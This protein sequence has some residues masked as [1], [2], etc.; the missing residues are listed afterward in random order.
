MNHSTLLPS[1][2]CLLASGGIA[3]AEPTAAETAKTDEKTGELSQALQ[4]FELASFQNVKS[5]RCIGVDGAS[6]ANGAL[7]KQFSCDS[8]SNQNWHIQRSG[9]EHTM[10]NQKSNRC[11]GVSG[12]SKTAGAN[13][14]QFG[15][16]G[17]ANQAWVLEALGG[18]TA[19]PIARF[20]NVNSNMCLGVDGAS[21]A[22]GAQLKQFPCDGSVNQQWRLIER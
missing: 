1:V 19:N 12:A 9:I 3:S 4:A 2:L 7:L 8:S 13:L 10:I 16:D 17:S 20:I 6:T 5:Q 18:T 14:G 15:C 22:N 21:T 11:M